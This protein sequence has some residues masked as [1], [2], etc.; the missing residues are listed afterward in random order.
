MDNSITVKSLNNIYCEQIVDVIIPIQRI[1]FNVDLS[2]E[3]Q[4]D[5]LDVEGN[6]HQTGGGFW[7]A[8]D[9]DRL[10]GTI[11]L[12]NLGNQAGGLRKMFVRKEYRGKDYN[13]AYKLLEILIDHC[14]A[15]GITDIYLGTIDILKAACRFYE[16]NGFVEVAKADLPS[17][18]P[19]M[20]TDNK[21]YHLHLKA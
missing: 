15:N 17:Y 1:E 2:V 16:K 5:L 8:L 11:A 10:T 6:Y 7:G 14:K 9:G 20:H 13:I 19:P 4:P 3:T 21:F 12:M 18:F